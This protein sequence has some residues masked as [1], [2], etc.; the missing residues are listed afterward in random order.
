MRFP[1]LAASALVMMAGTAHATV[2]EPVDLSPY[3][4]EGF[5]NSWF[6]NGSWFTPY[7]GLTHGN[8]GSQIPFEIANPSD[9]AGGH[10]NFWFGLYSGPG[11]LFGS[12][13]S[14]TI[15]V[16]GS[17][18]VKIHTLADNTFGKAG[19]LEYIMQLNG[20]P[21]YGDIVF[22]YIG[23]WNTKDYNRNCATTGCSATPGASY[24][25]WLGWQQLQRV[26]WS[27]PVGYQF[28]SITF[29]QMDGVD[30]AILAGVT[31]ETPEPLT[32]TLFGAGL[33]GAAA[34]RRRKRIA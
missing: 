1:W 5:T 14:I 23:A 2:F 27:V 28:D 20:A 6:I 16:S 13:N 9:G 11:T 21:G 26:S 29:T 15:P 31:L 18:V 34:A 8:F 30:G 32:L 25:L 17:N 24:Y 33:L 7:V 4:N 12:P 3:V 10:N 19:A 22:D